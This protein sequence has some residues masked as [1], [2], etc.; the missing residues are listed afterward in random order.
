MTAYRTLMAVLLAAVVAAEAS[1]VFA[2]GESPIVA[3]VPDAFPGDLPSL[4]IDG[5]RYRVRM[6]GTVGVNEIPVAVVEVTSLKDAACVARTDL[7]VATYVNTPSISRVP[8]IP[9]PIEVQKLPIDVTLEPGETKIVRLELDKGLTDPSKFNFGAPEYQVVIGSMPFEMGLEGRVSRRIA[10]IDTRNRAA[11]PARLTPRERAA[12]REITRTESETTE[13]TETETAPAETAVEETAEIVAPEAPQPGAVL[14]RFTIDATKVFEMKVDI[15]RDDTGRAIAATV[16][17]I[18]LSGVE[19]SRVWVNGGAHRGTAVSV[20]ATDETAAA[21]SGVI[22][23][24]A[25]ADDKS[26]SVNAI[27]INTDAEGVKIAAD[28]EH[29]VRFKIDSV[30]QDTIVVY[31]AAFGGLSQ[32]FAFSTLPEDADATETV[33]GTTDVIDPAVAPQTDEEIN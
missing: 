18:N 20:V 29:T 32:E 31:C 25:S 5:V 22:V 19:L 1:V 3:D 23:T 4:E 11:L 24:A 13:T 2:E 28:A 6:E 12:I 15:E 21:V 27:V 17:M 7:R 30:M 33:S 8:S 9:T 14:C 10:R 26:R 16:R